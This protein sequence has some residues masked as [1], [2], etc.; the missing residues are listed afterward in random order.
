MY[1]VT[2]AT[3]FLGKNIVDRLV[4]RGQVHCLVRSGSRE[5]FNV[6]N[7]ARWNGRARGVEGDLGRELLGLDPSQLTDVEHIVHCAALYD[8]RA[9]EDACRAANVDGTAHA[10]ALATALNATF[11]HVSSI[12]VAGDADG[13]FAEDDLDLGQGHG[14]PYARTKFEGEALVRAHGGLWRVY[15]PG[16]IVGS[17]QTGEADRVD[18]IAL[19]FPLIRRLRGTLPAWVPLPGYEG[20]PLPLAPVDFVAEAIDYLLHTDGLDGRTF[21][22][23]DPEPPTFGEAANLVA[24]AAHAPQFALR[25]TPELFVAFPIVGPLLRGLPMVK[26]ARE[27]YLGGADGGPMLRLVSGSTRIESTRTWEVLRAGGVSCP[28]F[29]SYA[30]RLWDHW[31][32]VLRPASARS[33]RDAVDGRIVVVTGASSGIG[34][35]VAQVLAAEGAH[36]VLVARSTDKIEALATA[37]REAGG[38]ATALPCDLADPASIDALITA[39]EELGGCDVLINNAGRSIR[40]PVS[41]STERFHDFERTMQLNY[42]GALRLIL[43][44]LPGMRARGRG[45]VVNVLSMGLQTRVPRYAA[46]IASKAA[47]EAASTSI[48]AE[49]LHDG[50]KFTAV[51]MPLVRTPMIAPSALYKTWPALEVDAAARM[52][53]K[54][55]IEQPARVSTSLGTMAMFTQLVAPHAGLRLLNRG[56]RMVPMDGEAGTERQSSGIL[57]KILRSATY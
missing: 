53:T 24:A 51:Y 20:G 11:H 50:V 16:M 42:F 49:V 52:V 54:A 26:R 12:S 40:R 45:H 13:D 41:Q 29:A 4:E 9:G 21:H 39:V 28:P 33:L 19:L 14:H 34:E 43:G 7:A 27:R 10:L 46:Y 37:I 22:L 44:F 18:G 1:L 15:R 48:H 8:L 30:W 23:V 35:E 36:T 32:R 25:V 38:V 2:G 55:I 47:L 6:L 5:R 3:G 57:G 56:A 31:D 17:T